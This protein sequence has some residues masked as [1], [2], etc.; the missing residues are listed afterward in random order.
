MTGVET[1]AARVKLHEIQINR[2]NFPLGSIL[3]LLRLLLAKDKQTL[4]IFAFFCLKQ[5][6]RNAANT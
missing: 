5:K 4:T 2:N 1:F 3:M 6:S